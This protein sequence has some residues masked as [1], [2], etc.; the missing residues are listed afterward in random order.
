MALQKQL[1]PSNTKTNRSTRPNQQPSP[2][3]KMY[4][5]NPA[6]Y[7]LTSS[8]LTM[9]PAPQV[10]GLAPER[11]LHGGV[12]LDRWYQWCALKDQGSYFRH[13]NPPLPPN[14]QPQC[15]RLAPF[16]SPLPWAEPVSASQK[17]SYGTSGQ[18]DKP[19]RR[20]QRFIVQARSATSVIRLC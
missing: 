14:A 7:S 9:L 8:I 3:R 6:D 13:C 5:K 11:V 17:R 16:F 1:S 19:W 2:T 4:V 12:H 10:L 15:T 18:Q 20:A